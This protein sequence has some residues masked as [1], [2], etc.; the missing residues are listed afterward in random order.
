MRKSIPNPTLMPIYVNGTMIPPG[1]SRDFDEADLPPEHRA[2]ETPPAE[3][4][5]PDPLVELV[6]TSVK[7]IV[8]GFETLSDE[9]LARLQGIEQEGQNRKSLLEAIAAEQLKRADAAIEKQNATAGGAP[10]GNGNGGV[11]NGAG[12][13]VE[14][15]QGGEGGGTTQTNPVTPEG[16]G[17]GA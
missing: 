11:P 9:D 10:E 3:D 14:G 16:K 13:T 4:L 12:G 5:P 2:P 15:G 1:E 6:K 8:A 7:V 17:E